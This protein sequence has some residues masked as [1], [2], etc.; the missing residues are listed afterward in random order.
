MC[1][2]GIELIAP[3]LLLD[4]IPDLEQTADSTATTEII[5]NAAGEVVIHVDACIAPAVQALWAAGVVTLSSCC[6]HAQPGDEHP[7]G[8]ITIQTKPGVGQ[9]GAV[10]LRRERYDEL[11]AAERATGGV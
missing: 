11:V 7:W 2:H 8:V 6:G 5:R 4:A 9:R 10:L 3:R 1:D